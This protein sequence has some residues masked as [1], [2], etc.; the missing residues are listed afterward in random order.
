MRRPRLGPLACVTLG[1]PDVC[2]AAAAYCD[3]F[4]TTAARAAS[5]DPA[6]AAAWGMAGAKEAPTALIQPPSGSLIRL[7]CAAGPPAQPFHRTGWAAAEWAVTNADAMTSRASHAGFTILVEPG[8]VGTGGN[9][10]AL[11]AA[12]PGGEGIYLTEISTPPP[13][14]ALPSGAGSNDRL[15]GAVLASSDLPTARGFF[16]NW[17]EVT[18][19]TDHQ[20]PVRVI[21]RV[22][23]LPA[24]TSH[25]VS[26]LQLAG[27]AILEIDQYPAS[28]TAS[29]PIHCNVPPGIVAMTFQADCLP[30]AP[31]HMLP[32][33]SEPPY[34]GR[35][36]WASQLPDGGV[37]EVVTAAGG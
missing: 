7:V 25:R 28:V 2:A 21:N 37:L 1:V 14:F 18:R 33:R 19:V 5:L 12:G 17:F 13:G 27:E 6:L 4:G 29:A 31:G 35:P 32:A 30:A 26:T 20:L 24:S 9:L 22:H 15:Y 34:L 16:E 8:P 11:Q 10:R 23:S 36:A 3:L